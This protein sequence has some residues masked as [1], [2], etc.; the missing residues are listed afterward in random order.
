MKYLILVLLLSGC[1][2]QDEYTKHM[3]AKENKG[4]TVCYNITD[5]KNLSGRFCIEYIG[6]VK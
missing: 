6:E 3:L 1:L 5:Q 4:K 2:S